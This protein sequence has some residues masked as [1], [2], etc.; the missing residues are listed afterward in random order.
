M[1][2][3]IGRTIGK[4]RI[5]KLLARGGMAEVYLGT[6]LTLARP[7]AVKLLH[8]FIEEEP[9][10][11]ERFQREARVVAGLRH[12]NIVQV[13]DFDT[14]DGHPYIVMEYLKGPTLATYL[15]YLSQ[16][17]K[18][19]PFDQIARLLKGLTAGLDYAHKQ[20][21]IHRD[22]KPANILLHNRTDEVPLDKTLPNDVEAIVTDF[23]LVRVINEASQTTSGILSGTPLYMSP[24]QARGDPID[25]RSDIYSL[26]IVLYEMLAGRLPFQADNTLTVLHM[27]IHATPLPIP[28]IPAGVQAVIDRAL[29]KNPDDRYQTSRELAIDYY[30]SIGM[31]A[32]AGIIQALNP[33][34]PV[35]IEPPIET[36]GSLTPKPV[37]LPAD[38]L[39]LLTHS[40]SSVRKLAVQ[41]LVGLLDGKHLGLAR[42][43]QEKLRE[44]AATDDSLT[45]RQIAVQAL[46]VR[47]LESDLPAPVETQKEKLNGKPSALP[48]KPWSPQKSFSPIVTWLKGIN[49]LPRLMGWKL[50]LPK[51]ERRFVGGI[52]G[53]GLGIVVLA[54]AGRLIV[55][56]I[57]ISAHT[58]TATV[59]L[60]QPPPFTSTPTI[61]PTLIQTGFATST[62]T[63]TATPTQTLTSTPTATRTRLPPW[64]AIPT[65]KR[66][67][68]KPPAL[69]H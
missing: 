15:R 66:R 35:P 44:I 40:N 18:R 30:R 7:V 69:P 65:R 17:K 29:L 21:V 37:S 6:H 25:H 53:I 27:H 10:L 3:W 51:L 41:E 68:T 61:T 2:E 9:S 36:P 47:G 23:G 62:R 13:F 22:I 24:E 8:S 59:T 16:R 67:P 46:N 48:R 26:G 38:L 33:V 64:T 14:I 56:G 60:T 43:A 20:G 57:A 58:P 52:L 11:L 49:P 12:P 50:T 4:V 19:V 45:L 1:P 54:G 63:L 34:S 42:A 32:E 39:E 5:E 31:T 28:G 55:T